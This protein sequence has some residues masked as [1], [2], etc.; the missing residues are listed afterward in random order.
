ME[1][2]DDG[3][4]DCSSGE[5]LAACYTR[6]ASIQVPTTTVRTDRRQFAQIDDKNGVADPCRATPAS[7]SAHIDD[8]DGVSNHATP[9]LSIEGVKEYNEHPAQIEYANELPLKVFFSAM[10][11]SRPTPYYYLHILN[12]FN[13]C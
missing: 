3:L 1:Q 10:N 8:K 12:F 6:L 13:D 5:D 2:M 7:E 4:P 11:A 9:R